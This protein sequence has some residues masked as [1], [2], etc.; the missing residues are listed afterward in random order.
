MREAVPLVLELVL[1]DPSCVRFVH[2]DVCEATRMRPELREAADAF[3]SQVRSSI[4]GTTATPA[5]APEG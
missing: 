1:R 4:T 2:G 5:A 3:V